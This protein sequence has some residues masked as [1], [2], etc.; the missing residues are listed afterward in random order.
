L[1]FRVPAADRIS[2]RIALQRDSQNLY[3]TCPSQLVQVW[4]DFGQMVLVLHQFCPI[5]QLF[6]PRLRATF[7]RKP[8]YEKVHGITEYWGAPVLAGVHRGRL[9]IFESRLSARELCIIN[10]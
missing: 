2:G 4:R 7:E 9:S 10:R 3:Q 5:A 6:P 1:I 8:K